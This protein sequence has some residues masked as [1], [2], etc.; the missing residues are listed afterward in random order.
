MKLIVLHK[1]YRFTRGSWLYMRLI[2][3]HEAYGYVSLL[4]LQEAYS[5]HETHN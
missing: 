3:S 4:V 5:L 1:T 2:S